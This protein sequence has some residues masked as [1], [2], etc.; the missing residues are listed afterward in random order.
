MME[1]IL[2]CISI[3]IKT[4][5][6]IFLIVILFSNQSHSSDDYCNFKKNNYL[7]ELNNKKNII[8][9]NIKTNNLR[10]WTRN[11]LKILKNNTFK[12]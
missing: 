3:T 4:S 6:K 11:N 2:Y 12:K 7:K 10:K 5:I 1:K 8:Q 9:I